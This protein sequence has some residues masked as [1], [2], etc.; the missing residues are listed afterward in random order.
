MGL[1]LFI[2]RF[3]WIIVYE[4]SEYQVMWVYLLE[5]NVLRL[6]LVHCCYQ[7]VSE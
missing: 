5:V 6:D 7:C 1:H 3:S 4:I 2:S